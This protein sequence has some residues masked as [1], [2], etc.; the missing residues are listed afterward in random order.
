MES[1]SVL[2]LF[3]WSQKSHERSFHKSGIKNI[4]HWIMLVSLELMAV[5]ILIKLYQ[6]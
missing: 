2:F 6:K 1:V 4:Q 3:S 5:P